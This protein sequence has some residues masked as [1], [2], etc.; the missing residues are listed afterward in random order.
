MGKKGSKKSSKSDSKN[1]TKKAKGTRDGAPILP[2]SSP[3]SVT[4]SVSAE[5]S[6]SPSNFPSV[7]LKPSSAPSDLP[8]TSANP[9]AA[10][11]DIP[12]LS[13]SPSISA[14]PTEFTGWRNAPTNEQYEALNDSDVEVVDS[15]FNSVDIAFDFVWF[16]TQLNSM[17]LFKNGYI[18]VEGG[19]YIEFIFAALFPSAGGLV[20]YLQKTGSIKISFEGVPFGLWVFGGVDGNVQAQVELFANGNMILCYGGDGDIPA[21]ISF[22]A[23]VYLE[24]EQDYISIPDAPFNSNGF[25]FVWPANTCWEYIMPK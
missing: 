21:G 15:D 18:H 23:V 17:T 22:R 16:G 14:Q 12:S 2:S 4:P 10:P 1:G 3:P 19:D 11:S 20:K 24:E 5:S 6:N 9:S 8:S 13:M 25:T 7:S